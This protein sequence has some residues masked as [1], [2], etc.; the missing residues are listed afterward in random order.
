M[1]DAPKPCFDGWSMEA[2]CPVNSTCFVFW[3]FLLI[4]VIHECCVRP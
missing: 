1:G 2:C 4:T 3:L